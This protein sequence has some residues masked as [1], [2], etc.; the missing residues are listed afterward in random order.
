M[1]THNPPTEPNS[2]GK[3]SSGPQPSEKTL[4]HK[5]D[6]TTEVV[7]GLVAKFQQNKIEK[8]EEANE[9]EHMEWKGGGWY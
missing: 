8:A 4:D 1:D 3:G 5:Q 2:L 6:A 7:Q 9:E